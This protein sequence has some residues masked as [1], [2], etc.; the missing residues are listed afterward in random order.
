MVFTELN[1]DVIAAIFIA[2]GCFI[3]PQTYAGWV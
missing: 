1:G 3:V 2:I